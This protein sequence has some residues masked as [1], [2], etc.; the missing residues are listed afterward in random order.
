MKKILPQKTKW[1]L[2]PLLALAITGCTSIKLNLFTGKSDPLQEFTLSG[3]GKDKVLIIPINGMIS[4][5]ADFSLL[6]EH[7]GMLENITAQLQCAK[8]DPE[9]KAILLKIDSPGGLVTTSDILYKEISDFKKE[10]GKIVVVSMMD[11]ATSGAYMVSLPVDMITA[12]P[13]T[14]TGSIGVVFMRP[15]ISDLMNKIGVKVD[16]SKSGRN[17]DMGSPFRQPTPEEDQMFQH[18]IDDFNKSFLDLVKK[19]RKIKPVDLQKIATA[20]IFIA[21][22][23]LKMGLIDKICY[24]N[25]A[26][27]EC[28]SMAK[29]SKN[30]KVVIYRRKY[31]PNDNIYNT[32]L[33]KTTGHRIS[34]INMGILNNLGAVKSGFYYIWPGAISG[35]L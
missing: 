23:A 15:Q 30:A 6:S 8:E 16:V 31:Y 11:F 2:M 7:A 27:D 34:L 12:H 29:L 1:I 14:V 21:K 25:E 17:K 22:D 35:D 26:L 13:T 32:S 24:L 20:R 5:S 9:I 33:S 3:S 19:H 18:I 10:T 28:K 4:N